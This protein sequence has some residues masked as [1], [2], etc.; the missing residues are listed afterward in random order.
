M[1]VDERAARARAVALGI[2]VTGTLGVLAQARRRGLIGPLMPL[3]ATLRAS[4]QR[5][6]HQAV[7]QALTASGEASE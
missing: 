3:I 5:L 4:G 1:L 7:A 6:S 2:V